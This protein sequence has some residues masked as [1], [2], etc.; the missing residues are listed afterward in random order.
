MTDKAL[1]TGI[2]DYRY[3]SDL[4]G[5]ENDVRNIERLLVDQFG[6]AQANIRTLLSGEVTKERVKRGWDWL[7]EEKDL[8][9]GDRLV[10]H[11]SGHGSY[12]ADVDG[13]EEAD[14]VDELICLHDMDF[15]DNQTYFID[16]E[17]R[18]FTQRVPRGVL[19]TVIL[20]DCHSGTGTRMA[21]APGMA[22]ARSLAPEKRPMV[23]LPTSMAR[24]EMSEGARSLGMR[25][26]GAA[27]ERF[28]AP[29]SAADERH[30]VLSRYV[31]PP[32]KI[33]D[34]LNRR[35]VRRGFRERAARDAADMNHVLWAGSRADQTSADAYIDGKFNGAFTYYFCDAARRTGASTDHQELIRQLRRALSRERFTQ[36]P[37]LE[38]AT[39]TGPL[40]RWQLAGPPAPSGVVPSVHCD[41]EFL[42]QLISL[43]EEVQRQRAAERA[44]GAAV[45]GERGFGDIVANL[46][47]AIGNFSDNLGKKLGTL[48]DDVTTLEVSTFACNQLESGNPADPQLRARTTIK[49]DGDTDVYVPQETGQID[50]RLW[51]IHT[52]TVKQAQEHR[53]KMIAAAVSAATGLMNVFKA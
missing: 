46:Q 15:D 53:A 16:D 23:D 21:M 6:F 51:T 33:L 37:Q 25:E 50:E 20:D 44:R 35:G 2:N 11:F 3:V 14:G 10:F 52:D 22:G 5:C 27:A 17:L 4:R 43:L 13:D 36:V 49:P 38:P 39:T 18:A 34:I 26:S 9:P 31:E 42:Q 47:Q 48:L 41:T 12:T 1:L 45:A 30:A 32:P 28:L 19:L 7:L 8:S 40:F 29:R 24:M